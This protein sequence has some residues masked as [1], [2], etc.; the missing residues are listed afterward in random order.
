MAKHIKPS[1][2]KNSINQHIDDK[3]TP[4]TSKQKEILTDSGHIMLIE[5]KSFRPSKKLYQFLQ[6]ENSILEKVDLIDYWNLQ[7]SGRN[8]Q[9]R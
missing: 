9:T 5:E 8:N 7:E 1:H 2:G 4:F 6:E 3:K